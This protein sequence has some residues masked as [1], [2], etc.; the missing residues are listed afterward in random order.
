MTTRSC[1]S[2]ASGQEH[3]LGVCPV[4]RYLHEIDLDGEMDVSGDVEPLIRLQDQINTTT[5]NLLMAQ[6]YG[7]FRQRWV[8]GMVPDEEGSPR[9]PFRAGVDRLWS[10][11][12]RTRNLV[13]SG[14]RTFRASLSR[15]KRRS[16]T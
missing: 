3:G 4:V 11:R 10:R 15:G 1:P 9:E 2:D 5:F 14:S 8:T 12:T 6:Q 7:A 13:S 16:R